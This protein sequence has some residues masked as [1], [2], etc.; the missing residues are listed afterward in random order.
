MY[1]WMSVCIAHKCDL[2]FFSF[3]VDL[4]AELLAVLL[5]LL[6][7]CVRFA[8][9]VDCR[10]CSVCHCSSKSNIIVYNESSVEPDDHKK[11][12]CNQKEHTEMFMH[13]FSHSGGL[14]VKLLLL[15]PQ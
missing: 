15:V 14:V 10:R 11:M 4:P 12:K 3:T 7:F 1:S 5:F 2:L 6:R 8:F 13:M 9:S